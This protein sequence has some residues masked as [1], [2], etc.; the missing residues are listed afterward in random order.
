MAKRKLKNTQ[1]LFSQAKN[2]LVGGVNSP[3]R[4]FCSVGGEP[5][6][7]K[8]GRG[9]YLVDYDNHRYLDYCLGWGAMILGHAY[10][11]VIRQIKQSL[12]SGL[13]FG[14]THK[15]EVDLAKTIC[16]AIPFVENLRF[17]NSGTE[18][19]MSALRLARGYKRREKII[20]FTNSYHG[21]A[22]FL[23]AR[24]GSGLASLN[25][26]TSAGVPRAYLRDTL[27]LPFGDAQLLE[28]TLRRFKHEIAAVLVEPIGGNY[29]VLPLDLEFLQQI[30]KLTKKYSTLLIFDEVITG[31][32][33]RFGSL[34]D[35]LG[36]TPDLV[37]LGKI[38]GGGLPIGAYGGSKEIMQNLA[39]LGKVY[40]ASTFAGNPIVMN[41]GIATLEALKKESSGYQR[42]IALTSL[43]VNA[44]RKLEVPAALGLKT[45]FYGNMFSLRFRERSFFNKVY[46]GL[47]K[48]GVYLAP[49]EFEANFISFVH[50]QEQ[51]NKT[52]IAFKH[53]LTD[54]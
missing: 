46:R 48:S 38:I 26:P 12:P 2:Y 49:S 5:V 29:G 11:G 53:A 45:D 25:I 9:A 10:P 7:F 47:L 37:C 30:R 8:E 44:I 22:D 28:A 15:S 20:K 16:R 43:L 3:V 41:A 24:A 35:S 14:A 51:I 19:V 13:G 54:L 18:A 23:L 39:P 1:R 6:L 32:R 27:V 21:H 4:S 17:V 50:T 36:I 33:F 34:G 52:I 40:Q 42:S 31:F